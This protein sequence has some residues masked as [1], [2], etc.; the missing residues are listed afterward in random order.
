[1]N[2]VWYGGTP[3]ACTKPC[4]PFWISAKISGYSRYW[5]TFGPC[6]RV[7]VWQKLI[8]WT[9]SVKQACWKASI[10]SA[11][12]RCFQP[13]VE[14]ADSYVLVVVAGQN[15]IT[16]QWD[17]CTTIALLL[18]QLFP[19]LLNLPFV[20]GFTYTLWWMGTDFYIHTPKSC[21]EAVMYTKGGQR[22]GQRHWFR[23]GISNKFILDVRVRGIQT[24]EHIGVWAICQNST[25]ICSVRM[26]VKLNFPRLFSLY[27]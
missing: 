9:G 21:R 2:T 15:T 24:F 12:N 4:P 14:S 10:Q 17:R 13:M 5:P 7:L 23:N 19:E 1:M 22:H 16:Q 11:S 3:V 20:P 8:S 26:P 18:Q 25:C 27:V 6:V